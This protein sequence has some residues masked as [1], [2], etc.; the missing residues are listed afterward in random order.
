[1]RKIE[2]TSQFERDFKRETKGL[3][4]KILEASFASVV[5]KLAEDQ[6]LEKKYRDHSL[7]GQWDGFR[8]CHIRPDLVLI[9]EKENC[10]LRLIRLG[11]HSEIG[12]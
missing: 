12:F 10:V 3:H 8:D 2:W 9:Y 5:Q 6:P 7:A 11:S 4:K 1:M